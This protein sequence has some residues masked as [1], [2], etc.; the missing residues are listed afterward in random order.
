M[1]AFETFD[2]SVCKR[3]IGEIQDRTWSRIVGEVFCNNWTYEASGHP[4]GTI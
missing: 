4:N 3:A 1:C 2:F